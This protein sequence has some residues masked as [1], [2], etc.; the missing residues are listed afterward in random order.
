[1]LFPSRTGPRSNDP[2]K[3]RDG[4][5][6]FRPMLEVLEDRITPS[7]VAAVPPPTNAAPDN[8][9]AVVAPVT[10]S[11]T[12]S[13]NQLTFTFSPARLIYTAGTTSVN[14]AVTITDPTTGAPV[15]GGTVTF[16]VTDANGN[17]VGTPVTVNVPSA[18]QEPSPTTDPISTSYTLPS[19]LPA[20]KYTVTAVY[21]Q[22]DSPFDGSQGSEILTLVLPPAPAQQI[23][24]PHTQSLARTQAAD[25]PALS[26]QQAALTLYLD[27]ITRA[28]DTFFHRPV[29]AVQASIDAALPYAGPWG[30]FFELAGEAAF[31]QANHGKTT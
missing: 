12:Q 23:G 24:Q 7:N 2:R 8:S 4:H 25:P 17:T 10:Q 20:N 13:Q 6:Q 16:T 9:P 18:G 14:I 15:S 26:L 19:N 11:N 1:M 29:D 22:S 27:G 21:H 28:W 30:A 31:Y 3:N 5:Q